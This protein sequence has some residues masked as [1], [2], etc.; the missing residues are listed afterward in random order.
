MQTATITKK[1]IRTIIIEGVRDAFD[2]ELTKF[3]TLALPFVS[4]KEQREIIKSLRRVDRSVGKK[5]YVTL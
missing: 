2:L 4:Q 1:E 3:R 5:I